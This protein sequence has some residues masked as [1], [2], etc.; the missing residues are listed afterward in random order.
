VQ[1]RPAL[2]AHRYAHRKQTVEARTDGSK[3]CR[4]CGLTKPRLDYYAHPNGPDGRAPRCKQCER[5]RLQRRKHG[6]TGAEKA[7]VAREQG[8]CAIC[9][10]PEPSAK[11]WVV[12]HDHTCCS[13]EK[14]CEKCR[15]GVLCQ[16][17]NNVLGYALDNAD[18]LRA[19]A[20][21]LDLCTGLST[22]AVHRSYERTDGQN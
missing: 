1:L 15:R 13:G 20:Q 3:V 12:D 22:G 8:G 6:M 4:G 19:A 16:W 17:C 21:Y 18:T 14:S 5:D 11:G 9:H 10:R 7:A 2:D